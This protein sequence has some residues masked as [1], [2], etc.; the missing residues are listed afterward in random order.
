MELLNVGIKIIFDG[1]NEL[2]WMN[3]QFSF[4]LISVKHLVLISRKIDLAVCKS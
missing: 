1:M 3:K 4:V 2:F